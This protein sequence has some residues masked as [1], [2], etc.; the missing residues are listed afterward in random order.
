MLYSLGVLQSLMLYTPLKVYTVSLWSPEST[1][2]AAT[3][4]N[5]TCANSKVN[6]RSSSHMQCV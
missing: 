1:A 4:E 6:N 2:R 3:E 5:S